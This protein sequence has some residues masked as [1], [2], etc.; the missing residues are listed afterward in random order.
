MGPCQGK[1]CGQTAVELCAR[2]TGR[3]INT[4]GV[5]TSRPPV[6]P[7]ELAVL[8]SA[9]RRAPVRR[10]SLHHWH[11]A[12]GARWLD[13]GQWKRP[14]SYG[15]PAAEVQAVRTAVGLI[16]VSTLGKLEVVGPDALELLQRVYV[17]KWADLKTG[18]IRYGVMCNEDGILLDDGVGARLGPDRF[19]LTATTGNAQGIFEWLELW[20]ATWRLNVSV[21][22]QTSGWAAMNLAGPQARAV[23]QRLTDLDVSPA[24]LPYLSVRE[25]EV[26]GVRCR[27]L[28]IGFVGELGYE[29]H[30]PTGYAWHLWEALCRAGQE[31]GLKPF[32]VEAQRILRLEKG[33]LISARTPMLFRLPLKPAWSGWSVS[34][35]RSSMGGNRCYA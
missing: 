29:I 2:A 3:D 35:N 5:T 23:L 17:N 33:H 13:A 24:G 10:T 19:Y 21:L 7:V 1:V 14:E 12:A 18:R 4:V 11:G 8:A 34:K 15:D 20:R 22:N 30:C 32:G 9:R 27:I 16:D 25:G 31:F 6:V 26:A 28:R